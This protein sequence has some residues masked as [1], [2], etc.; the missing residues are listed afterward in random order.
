MQTES[1]SLGAVVVWKLRGKRATSSQIT[2]SHDKHCFT[3]NETLCLPATLH[4]Q[5]RESCVFSELPSTLTL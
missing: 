4:K 3:F 2:L 1:W 5:S